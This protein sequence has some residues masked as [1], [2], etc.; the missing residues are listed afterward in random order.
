MLSRQCHERPLIIYTGNFFGHWNSKYRYFAGAD[1]G[2]L[3]GGG[4]GFHDLKKSYQA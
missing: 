3:K 1:T 4:V 2:I